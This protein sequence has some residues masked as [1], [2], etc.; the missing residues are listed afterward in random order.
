M[1][2]ESRKSRHLSKWILFSALLLTVPVPYFMIVIGG[3][4]PT[5]YIIYIAVYGLFVALP[6]FTAEGFWMLGILWAHVAI[7]GTILYLMAGGISWLLFR[8]LPPRYGLLTVIVLIIALFILSTFEIYRSPGHNS[9]PPANIFQ[10]L[11]SLAI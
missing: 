7:L 11:N 3:L 5:F 4:V 10:I 1:N 6:K 8:I 2:L 9:S